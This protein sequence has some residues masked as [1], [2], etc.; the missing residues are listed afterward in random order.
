MVKLLKSESMSDI[1]WNITDND[2]T[3]IWYQNSDMIRHM[4]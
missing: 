1:G 4:I 3:Y 2:M